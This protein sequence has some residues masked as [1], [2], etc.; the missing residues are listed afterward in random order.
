MMDANRTVFD[1][2]Y[3]V[4]G[5]AIA[6]DWLVVF[7]AKYLVYVL[8]ALF[9]G[10]LLKGKYWKQQALYFSLATLG[11]IVARGILTPIIGVL[12]STPRP[13]RALGIEPLFVVNDATSFP[14]GHMAFLTPL[15]ATLWF[16]NKKWSAWFSVASVFVGVARITAGVHWPLDIV[17][18]ILVGI[19]GFGVAYLV[20]RKPLL[21]VRSTGDRGARVDEEAT[22]AH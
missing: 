19:A 21:A 22:Q 17:G 15:A 18:G 8:A 13:F 9:L 14:S 3:A 1:A 7:F 11:I 20:V 4:S 12:L 16:L 5:R 6:L 2:L 10:C